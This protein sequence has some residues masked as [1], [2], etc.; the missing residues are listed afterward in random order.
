MARTGGIGLTCVTC[1]ARRLGINEAERYGDNSPA[2]GSLVL[3]MHGVTQARTEQDGISSGWAIDNALMTYRANGA[4]CLVFRLVGGFLSAM[5]TA[6][7]II[8][9]HVLEVVRMLHLAPTNPGDRGKG[10][11]E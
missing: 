8:L 4:P 11:D 10:D 9:Q 3:I 5:M 6:A 7:R 1:D 2:C